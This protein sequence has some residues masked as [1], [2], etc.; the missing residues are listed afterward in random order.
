MAGW[1]QHV[2]VQSVDPF[3]VLQ[4]VPDGT[5][6]IVKARS[7]CST[8]RGRNN[9]VAMDCS[10]LIVCKYTFVRKGWATVPA[11]LMLGIIASITAGI[12]NVSWTNIRSAS[13]MNSISRAQSAAESGLSFGARRLHS[14]VNRYV[15]DQ[16]V[17][18]ASLA[19]KLWLGTW[20]PADGLITVT[21]PA[22]YS[23]NSATGIGIV[24]ALY[25]V[26]D[27]I[28][29]H[30][31]ERVIGDA[32][33]P[34]L[35]NNDYRLE[36]K[37]IAL[38][39]ESNG[40]LFRLSYEFLSGDTKILITSI[41]ESD[42]IARAISMEFDLDKRI[43]YAVIAMSR[44]MLG[45]NVIVEGPV[46]TRYGTDADELNNKFGVPLVMQSDFSGLD[47]GVLDVLLDTFSLLVQA[48]DVDGDNRLRVNHTLEKNGLGG[49]FIDY[50]GDEFV[51]DFDLFLAHFDAN[52]DI[53]VVFDS[54]QAAAAGFPGLSQEFNNDTQLA[55]LIDHARADRNGDGIGKQ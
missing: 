34:A 25:D 12:A 33:L 1:S 31:V 36:V 28:D 32:L 6:E 10:T 45:K 38:D 54:A 13:A 9:E 52:G 41:G 39:S 23:I 40:P 37:P 22:E 17:I 21:S 26:F 47:T 42:G 46:G 18:D 4:V 19:D 5:S 24:H 35:S 48:D 14:E 7:H 11:L 8:K 2:T 29:L 51:T 30:A 27:E 43:D 20:T 44:L 15:I 55:L 50:D 16:G 53:A 49:S 3:N